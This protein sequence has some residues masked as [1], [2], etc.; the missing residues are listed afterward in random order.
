MILI[1]HDHFFF[2]PNVFINKTVPCPRASLEMEVKPGPFQNSLSAR[3]FEKEHRA[4]LAPGRA[5][6]PPG[7]AGGNE[8]N[9]TRGLPS[10]PRAAGLIVFSGPELL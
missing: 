1:Q 8:G 3:S 4:V 7:A 5:G 2:L 10:A 6:V 9:Y